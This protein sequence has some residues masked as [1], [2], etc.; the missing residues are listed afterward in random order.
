MNNYDNWKLSSPPEN[1]E[2][3][4]V[5]QCEMCLEPF[6]YADLENYFVN[7]KPY[8]VCIDCKVNI[9][10][11]KELKIKLIKTKTM[12]LEL[13]KLKAQMDKDYLTMSERID[14]SLAVIRAELTQL[15]IAKS[16]L[17]LKILSK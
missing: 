1:N 3:R 12:D 10:E 14:L 5:G 7:L 17:R 9:Q 11:D 4:E 2:P 15:E 6:E 16:E 13:L 8:L